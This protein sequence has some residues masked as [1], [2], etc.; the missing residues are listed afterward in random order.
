MTGEYIGIGEAND[1]K[2]EIKPT[3]FVKPI[4]RSVPM[5][6]G[7]WKQEE[8]IMITGIS[9]L[10]QDMNTLSPKDLLPNEELFYVEEVVEK[11]KL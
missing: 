8:Q 1:F 2:Y 10:N 6:Q 5:S 9:K 3:P 7:G 4:R 11:A